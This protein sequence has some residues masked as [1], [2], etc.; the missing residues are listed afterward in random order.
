MTSISANKSILIL[1][2]LLCSTLANAITIDTEAIF[3]AKLQPQVKIPDYY[4]I[5]NVRN[6][7]EVYQALNKAHQVGG[8]AAILFADGIYH[9]KR[10]INISADNIMLLSTS[11]TPVNTILRGNGMKST[12]GVENLIRVSGKHFVIDG[13]TLEQTGNHLIQIAGENGA[14]NPI[15]RN[16][17]LQDGYEQLLKVTYSRKHSDRFST[18]GLVENCL[19]RYTNGIGPNFYI[20]GID[21]HGIKNWQIKNNIFENIASPNKYIAEHAIHLWNDTAHNTIKN[22]LIINSDRGIGLGMRLKKHNYNTHSNFAGVVEGNII[23]HA[24]NNHEFADVGIILEDSPETIIRD[25]FIYFEHD[26]PNAIE[27]RF[28][29]TIDVLISNNETNRGIVLRNHAQALIINNRIAE[30]TKSSLILAIAALTSKAAVL[31][32]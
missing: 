9:L 32:Q 2:A 21:A 25:N 20:G 6:A 12:K 13:L 3:L 23:Y 30:L 27:F 29:K 10:T 8:Y 19:F 15:I 1:L 17:I 28:N 4:K 5:Y 18:N 22:N 11:A 16:T 7:N 26:Y 31:S 14:I 24:K